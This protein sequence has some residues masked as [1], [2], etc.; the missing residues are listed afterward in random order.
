MFHSI[1]L[2]SVFTTLEVCVATLSCLK[3]CLFFL[4]LNDSQVSIKHFHRNV[5]CSENKWKI[6]NDLQKAWRTFAQSHCKKSPSLKWASIWRLSI[7]SLFQIWNDHIYSTYSI[8]FNKNNNN[9]TVDNWKVFCL[10]KKNKYTRE[11]HF[12]FLFWWV[13][14][15]RHFFDSIQA[16]KIAASL[17]RNTKTRNKTSALKQNK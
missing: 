15:G 11:L 16:L 8:L 5:N 13:Q 17:F 10:K 7:L 2:F 1:K 12:T 9:W 3:I 6:E 4:P 14:F